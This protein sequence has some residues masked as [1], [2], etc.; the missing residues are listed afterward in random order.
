MFLAVS[1]DAIFSFAPLRGY[2]VTIFEE[3]RLKAYFKAT[4][5][6]HAFPDLSTLVCFRWEEPCVPW[7]LTIAFGL[8]G[9]F[10]NG[11]Y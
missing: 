5:L 9:P 10:A 2:E 7:F 11:I 4:H 8:D 6:T 3:N 1:F